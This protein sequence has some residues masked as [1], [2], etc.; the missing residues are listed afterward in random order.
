MQRGNPPSGQC[1]AGHGFRANRILVP[2]KIAIRSNSRPRLAVDEPETADSR[3]IQSK[4]SLA[5]AIFFVVSPPAP[6][7]PHTA[8]RRAMR[9]S[10][11][12]ATD[13][14]DT[15]GAARDLPRFACRCLRTVN[16]AGKSGYFGPK[17]TKTMPEIPCGVS[18]IANRSDD[19]YLLNSATDFCAA[20]TLS[21]AVTFL[22]AAMACGFI[23]LA[24]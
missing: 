2:R 8:A 12:D 22:S 4:R 5:G 24:L 13:N 18:G 21:P 14:I 20:A 11:A 10:A 23:S 3:I 17:N 16:T 6:P 1:G 9:P 7:L 19:R 15:T